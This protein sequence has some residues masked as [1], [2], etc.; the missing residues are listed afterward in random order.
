MSDNKLVKAI[1][2]AQ[3]SQALS[4]GLVGLGARSSKKT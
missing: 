4:L 3:P 1:L 2:D